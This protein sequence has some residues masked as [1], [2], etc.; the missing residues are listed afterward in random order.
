MTK[1]LKTKA[2]QVQSHQ[3]ASLMRAPVRT[4]TPLA[5]RRPSAPVA[6]PRGGLAAPVSLPPAVTPYSLSGQIGGGQ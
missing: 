5:A 4:P 1:V 2:K 3:I 6:T